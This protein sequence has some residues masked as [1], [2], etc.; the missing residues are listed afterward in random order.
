MKGVYVHKIAS[1]L[2]RSKESKQYLDDTELITSGCNAGKRPQSYHWQLSI[3]CWSCSAL[4]VPLLHVAFFIQMC[5]AIHIS[6]RLLAPW[7]AQLARSYFNHMSLFCVFLRAE[8]GD[9][10]WEEALRFAVSLYLMLKLFLEKFIAMGPWP[11]QGPRLSFNLLADISASSA[12]LF[13]TQPIRLNDQKKKILHY[14]IY[15]PLRKGT[16][17]LRVM[18]HAHI[19]CRYSKSMSENPRNHGYKESVATLMLSLHFNCKVF[20]VCL[21]CS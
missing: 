17:T 11:E 16:N 4:T 7:S 10:S 2:F 14:C 15:F 20:S 19:C 1:S 13:T 6:L 18:C 21:I 12:F 8:A 9:A 3:Q 5:W